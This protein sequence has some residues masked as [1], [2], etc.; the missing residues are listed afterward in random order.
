MP[1]DI[2]IKK[3]NIRDIQPRE[4]EYPVSPPFRSIDLFVRSGIRRIPEAD[5]RACI[6][7]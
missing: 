1:P 5:F 3:A 2:R 4:F 6:R 7:E